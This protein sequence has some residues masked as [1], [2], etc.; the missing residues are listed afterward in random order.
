MEYQDL[1]KS[2]AIKLILG[3]SAIIGKKIVYNGDEVLLKI[4]KDD[5][6]ESE[7]KIFSKILEAEQNKKKEK[8]VDK[9]L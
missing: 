6:T 2:V 3:R 5:L 7:I 4:N 9:Q 8:E 1:G